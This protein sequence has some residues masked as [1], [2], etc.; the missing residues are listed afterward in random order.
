METLLEA[1]NL[2]KD[3]T[4]PVLKGVSFSLHGGECLGLVGRS[5]CGKSTLAR[6]VTRLLPADGGKIFLCGR[7]ITH[8][9]GREMIEAYGKMQMVFQMPE[10]SFDPRHT[11]G[12]SIGE[13]MRNRGWEKKRIKERVEGLLEEVG[14][15]PSY[16]ER[17]PHEVSGGEC[18]RAAIA[19]ALALSPRVLVC[20]EATSALDM[21]VQAG[22]VELIG[23]LVGK[24][25]A[26]LFITH[27]IALLA[28]LAHRVMVMHEGRIVEEGPTGE[29]LRKAESP[30]ARELVEAAL[31]RMAMGENGWMRR[32]EPDDVCREMPVS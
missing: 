2:R 26:C 3:F 24:G 31:F 22:I 19:R 29:F 10:D 32:G 14:L 15:S 21:T 5:G 8:A 20:D 27:D 4:H 6:V 12:W 11:L 17:Y 30:Q 9:S 16:G 7:D 25:L 23:K 13:P 1:R 18:Q 28:G